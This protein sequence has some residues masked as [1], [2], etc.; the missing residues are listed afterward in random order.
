MTPRVTLPA[1][2]VL[3]LFLA[4][5]PAGAQT[6]T[7]NASPSIVHVG[8]TVT[9]NG[10]VSGVH[11]IAVYLFVTG[12]DLDSRGVT[13]DNLNIPTGHGLFTTA[14]VDMKTGNWSY[15]W[16]TSII[17][18]NMNPGKYTVYVLTSPVDRERF[19]K[20]DYASADITFLPPKTESAHIP[21]SPGVT[22][23]ALVIT[24]ITGSFMIRRVK[25]A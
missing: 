22:I 6:I 14:V 18:G 16:D 1:A 20:G 9:L 10:S 19:S 25:N 11:T 7:I 8:D 5:L 13:L 24:I 15:S 3:L 23:M 21:L 4:I 2:V 17:L 12:P